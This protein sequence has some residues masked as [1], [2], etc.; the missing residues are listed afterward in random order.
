M[1]VANTTMNVVI[2]GNEERYL[3]LFMSAQ[4]VSLDAF[5]PMSGSLLAKLLQ[6]ASLAV[7]SSLQLILLPH[8]A[9]GFHTG[10]GILRDV[11]ITLLL[12]S[13]SHQLYPQAR[14]K[15]DAIRLKE[16]YRRER[17]CCCRSARSLVFRPPDL[18]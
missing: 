11:G 3:P 9:H 14:P 5:W 1:H 13:W 6:Q 4:Q 16:V 10:F 12:Y 2:S 18:A 7:G 8:L 17:S 15:L